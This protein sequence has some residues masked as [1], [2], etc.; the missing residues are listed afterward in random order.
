MQGVQKPRAAVKAAKE[1][2]TRNPEL[3][4]MRFKVS[5]RNE[6]AA[7]VKEVPQE[8]EKG[9]NEPFVAS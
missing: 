8:V 5:K 7:C 3:R 2:I 9:K 6:A 1:V 4:S